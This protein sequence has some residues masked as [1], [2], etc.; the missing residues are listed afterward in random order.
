MTTQWTPETWRSV[1]V[2]TGKVASEG[3]FLSGAAVFHQRAS[4][5]EALSVPLPQPALLTTEGALRAMLVVQAER[6]HRPDGPVE[7]F[8]AYAPDGSRFV[9]TS[10]ECRLVDENDPTWRRLSGGQQ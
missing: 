3:D 6:A 10:A 9:F 5:V 4:R 8:G 2:F 7:L 1:S